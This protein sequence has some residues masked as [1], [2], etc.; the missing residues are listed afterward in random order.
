M[1][2]NEKLKNKREI[3]KK[4]IYFLIFGVIA[5]VLLVILIPKITNNAV[6]IGGYRIFRIISESMVPVY[7][8]NDVIVV[9]E[10]KHDEIQIG[11]DLVY[12]GRTGEINGIIITHRVVDIEKDEDGKFGFYTKG[13]VNLNADPIVSE[14]QVYGVVVYKIHIL[15]MISKIINNIYGFSLF[16]FIPLVILICMKI[17]ELISNI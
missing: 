4:I 2:E 13:L 7:E 11:D 10:K 8:K 9:K 5:I 6:S 17:K 16:V 3:L 12:V 1:M 14:D 15:S